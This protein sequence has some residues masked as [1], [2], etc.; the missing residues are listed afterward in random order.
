MLR[1]CVSVALVIQHAMRIRHIVTYDLPGRV[2][3]FQSCLINGT[4]FGTKEVIGLKI[5]AIILFTY[6]F[7]KISY[8]KKKSVMHCDKC[9]CLRVKSGA[10]LGP[11]QTRQLPRAVDLKGRLLSFQSY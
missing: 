9:T 8:C 1:V 4:I 6:L 5:R 2:I 3:F 11:R 10:N 7:P